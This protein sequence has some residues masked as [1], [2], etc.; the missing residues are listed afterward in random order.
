VVSFWFLLRWFAD[1]EICSDFFFSD[2]KKCSCYKIIQIR[3]LFKFKNCSP[4]KFVQI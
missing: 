2:L 3:N 1:F 4:L